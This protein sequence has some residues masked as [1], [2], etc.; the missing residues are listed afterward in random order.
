MYEYSTVHSLCYN[1]SAHSRVPS[2]AVRVAWLRYWLWL[3]RSG[4]RT[5]WLM[6]V[7]HYGGGAGQSPRAEDTACAQSNDGARVLQMESL[8]RQLEAL[9]LE[10][11]PALRR[12][13][14]SHPQILHILD[15]QLPLAHT[16][17]REPLGWQLVVARGAVPAPQTRH[18]ISDFWFLIPDD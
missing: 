3:Q 15:L 14:P 6:R 1:F 16:P 17:Q 10:S 8:D 5:G 12:P 4:R 18:I 13:P 9:C 11:T 7:L 2:L